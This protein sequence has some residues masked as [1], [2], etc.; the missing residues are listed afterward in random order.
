MTY[1]CALCGRER[2]GNMTPGA[3]ITC[4]ECVHFLLESTPEK[5]KSLYEKVKEQGLYDKV[6]I[7][8]RWLPEETEDAESGRDLGRGRH[9]QT[10]LLT[11]ERN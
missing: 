10:V 11:K 6:R 7:L 2:K 3:K 1:V 8:K 5:I 4:W 9:N